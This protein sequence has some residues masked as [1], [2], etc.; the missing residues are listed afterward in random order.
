[1]ILSCSTKFTEKSYSTYWIH[2]I[3]QSSTARGCLKRNFYWKSRKPGLRLPTWTPLRIGRP[4][5]KKL[6]F[7]EWVNSCDPRQTVHVFLRRQQCKLHCQ[8]NQRSS[9]TLRRAELQGVQGKRKKTTAEHRLRRATL[10]CA[11]P[12]ESSYS[13]LAPVTG[14]DSPPC[15]RA[16][17]PVG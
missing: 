15:A 2:D 12:W 14:S 1:M 11:D 7:K 10:R 6:Q 9:A 13:S 3:D 8:K 4:I 17:K 5:G 16:E